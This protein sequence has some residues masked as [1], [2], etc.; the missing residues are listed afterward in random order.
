M[1]WVAGIGHRTEL[2]R[3]DDRV[4]TRVG[5]LK[6]GEIQRRIGLVGE[7]RAVKEPLIE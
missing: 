3:D 4:D 6:I 5:Q 2:V 7:G 1:T